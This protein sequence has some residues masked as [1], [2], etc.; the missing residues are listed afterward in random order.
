ME[1]VNSVGNAELCVEQGLNLLLAC[2]IG[3]AGDGML[4]ALG[5]LGFDNVSEDEMDIGGPGV[6][7]ELASKLKMD[8]SAVTGCKE[9]RGSLTIPPSHPAAPVIRT[10][11]L[12]PE[13]DPLTAVIMCIISR[14]VIRQ[15]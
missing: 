8:L 10:T 15:G 1:A 13:T 9:R 14:F 3:L 7:E 12:S 5:S 2:K 4:S 11:L 6:G